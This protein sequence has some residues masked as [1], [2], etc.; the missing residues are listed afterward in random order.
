MKR[1][2]SKEQEKNVATTISRFVELDNDRHVLRIKDSANM[3]VDF[4]EIGQPDVNLRFIV[5]V[6]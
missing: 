5:R 4:R 3:E 2:T 1:V 6:D